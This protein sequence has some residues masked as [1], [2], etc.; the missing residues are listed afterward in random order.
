MTLFIEIL[1][2][3]L[4]N[5]FWLVCFVLFLIKN[6]CWLKFSLQDFFFRF[7]LKC[8]LLK[9]NFLYIY[10]LF[11]CS[12]KPEVVSRI[13]LLILRETSRGAN[14][15][16]FFFS[17]HFFK[18][19]RSDSQILIVFCIEFW[20]NFHSQLWW[21]LHCYHSQVLGPVWYLPLVTS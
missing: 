1:F 3:H 10:W 6:S 9:R 13:W 21:T 19:K 15:S 11:V 18:A 14:V 5:V 2:L 7:Y 12:S 8:I 16:P 17:A 4:I 20:R